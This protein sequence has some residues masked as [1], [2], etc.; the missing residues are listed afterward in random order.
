MG[1]S[2]R[3]SPVLVVRA[4]VVVDGIACEDVGEFETCPAC[5]EA[6]HLFKCLLTSLF[7]GDDAVGADVLRGSEGGVHL[8]YEPIDLAILGL[9]CEHGCPS[10][11][12]HA[13]EKTGKKRFH[14]LKVNDS[15]VKSK[16]L[17]FNLF[18]GYF[19]N[20]PLMAS[21]FEWSSEIFVHDFACRL[22]IDKTSWHDEYVGVVVL[23]DKVGNFGSPAEAAADARVLVHRHGNAFAGAADGDAVV[24][25][26]PFN[27]IGQRMTEVGIVAAFLRVGTE[28]VVVV[29][30]LIEVFLYK[31]F[32]AEASVI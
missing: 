22:L 18:K 17:F 12:Q 8:T 16:F 31:L 29:T 19:L 7:T 26:A 27:G 25:L 10:G 4:S 21:T 13:E 28:V 23:A 6:P 1:G 9:G 24:Y 2:V 5:I 30:P 15:S 32:K 20:S 11:K 14:R 3:V